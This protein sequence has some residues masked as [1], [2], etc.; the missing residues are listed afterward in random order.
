M[1]SSRHIAHSAGFGPERRS[2]LDMALAGDVIVLLAG[3]SLAIG[4]RRLRATSA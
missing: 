1:R 2:P 4:R 3:G